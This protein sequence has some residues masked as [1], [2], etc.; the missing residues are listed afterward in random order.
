M[1]DTIDNYTLVSQ[2]DRKIQYQM[3][4]NGKNIMP[5]QLQYRLTP[6]IISNFDI[7]GLLIKHPINSIS[8]LDGFKEVSEQDISIEKCI[9]NTKKGREGNWK[10]LIGIKANDHLGYKVA[11]LNTLNNEIALMTTF[12]LNPDDPYRHRSISSKNDNW[13]ICQCKMIAPVL[14]WHLLYNWAII[15][16]RT[17]E[18]CIRA[19]SPIQET[20]LNPSQTSNKPPPLML[21]G[22]RPS[23][24]LGNE[25]YLKSQI[26]DLKKR[27][28][29]S[30][31]REK[32][33]KNQLLQV[34]EE[35]KLVTEQLVYPVIFQE[36]ENEYKVQIRDLK[37][38][39]IKLNKTYLIRDLKSKLL[40]L[41]KT[42]LKTTKFGDKWG[43]LQ[44]EDIKRLRPKYEGAIEF[45]TEEQFW[46]KYGWDTPQGPELEIII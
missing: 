41:N 36:I 39:L 24:M 27:L 37:S 46:T 2:K 7:H 22:N 18:E 16:L 14:F 29:E 26:E 10:F 38:E 42:Y 5:G 28:N 17:T 9:P 21:G 43:L 15:S 33:L 3:Y 11:L 4:K 35:F 13:K 1:T 12:K 45:C 31:E 20:D 23:S 30:Q 44:K 6:N 34:K 8:Y 32:S 19:P 25:L 40:K